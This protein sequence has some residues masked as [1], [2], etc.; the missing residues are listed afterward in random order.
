MERLTPQQR[1]QKL[2][3]RAR[4]DEMRQR[5]GMRPIEWKPIRETRNA[6]A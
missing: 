4:V 2:L 6:A 3:M 5:Q 1:A